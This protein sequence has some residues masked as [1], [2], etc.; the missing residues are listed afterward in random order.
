MSSRHYY[1]KVLVC[2]AAA[3]LGVATMTR[4]GKVEAGGQDAVSF[5]RDVRPIFSDT[6]FRCHGPDGN[7]RKAGLRLDIREEA[8]KK[9]KSGVIPIVP[10]KPEESEVV[11]RIFASEK[12][13]VMPPPALHKELTAQQKEI[14][15]RWIAEGARYEGHWAFQPIHRPAVPAL[16]A[17]SGGSFTRNPVDAFIEARL[18]KE[19]L[20][21]APEAD[22]QRLI[23]RVTLDL[24]GLPPTIEEIDNF[25][26]DRSPN[27][28]EKV[29]D[30]LLT[31][32]RYGERMT[33]RWLDAAR[34]ADTNGYQSDGERKMWRWR[35]WVI[36]SF[37]QNKP[38]DQFIIEQ[39]A[40]D[41][42]PNAT[43]DQKIA[44]AFN[45]NHRINSEGG[46]VPEE[47]AVEY[48]VDRVD[49]TS[50]VFMG[51]TLGCARCRDHK[52]DP[53]TQKEYY[54][55]FAYFNG[56]RESGRA[57]DQD[58]S[59]PWIAAPDREQQR[60][61]LELENRIA[62]AEAQ[63]AAMDK[64]LAV[65]QRRWEKSLL[66]RPDQQWLWGD[67]GLRV[68]TKNSFPLGR[69]H[70][71]LVA[72]D[73]T[74][75]YDL[76]SVYVDGQ[77][78]QLKLNQSI[79]YRFFK[80][81][82]ARL[83]IGGGG[84]P[85][86][87]FKGALDEARIY[88]ALP[89]ADGI[90]ILSCA[91][92]LQKIAALNPGKR[93]GTQRLKLRQ[94]FLAQA[95]PAPARRL[96]GSLAELKERRIKLV[97]EIPTLMVMEEMP[98]PKPALLLKRGAYDAPGEKVSRGTPAALPPTPKEFPDNRLGFAK[99]LVHPSNPL[100]ARVTVNRFWQMLFGTGL[101]KTTEDFG[102]QGE[103]PSHPE[104]LDSLA[105]EFR[106]SGWDVKR[107]LKTI[108]TSATYRQSSKAAPA[109]IQRDPE[110]RLHARGP[111]LRLPAEMIRDQALFVSGLLVEKTGGPSVKGYQPEGLYNDLVFN[112]TKYAQGT[113]AALY[114]RSLYTFWKRTIAPPFM[115]TFDAA[116]RET[117]VVR[118]QRTNTPLQ[119]LN[120][121]NDVTFIEAA[122]M[123]AQRAI[124]EGGATPEARLRYM[125]RLALGRFPST[126]EQ[127]IL[128]ANWRT[129]L[130][131]FRAD[132][133]GAAR[134][135]SM[136][137]KKNDP[138][139]DANQL[140]AYATVASLI[141]NLDEFV[142]KE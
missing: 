40:G 95:A 18:A 36:E 112:E 43:L 117:C 88:A 25:L 140:A 78:Q 137:E 115:L 30:R 46:I 106:E 114:R 22:R 1:K 107:L 104:L 48:V 136:G 94:A 26:N 3:L 64:R 134:L 77:K 90:A 51:L 80:I 23:R 85:D 67:D 53:I 65:A 29:V 59:A 121:M 60:K 61:L 10:G 31:S 50:T 7:A 55:L 62:R 81:K 44:T 20:R 100:T 71:A 129:Q 72:F 2:L 96:W 56:I 123:L 75:P 39:L 14:I 73:G 113:G 132:P 125:F 32:P 57:Y 19:G 6:C 34:Y 97:D 27:A 122:R 38:F 13:E 133:T 103:W 84:G 11:R 33:F 102:A 118:E 16:S 58:N 70:H 35:D 49:T 79:I 98:E 127:Q 41:L 87:R 45:R 139:L 116:N 130:D 54:Q 21:P 135:L 66:S 105:V 93:T 74:Q 24:T 69:W 86:L 109:L 111:R 119:A 138:R 99:W 142:T 47:Y 89:E 12:Y 68:E 131:Q 8:T 37:N 76:V 92:S 128:L 5:N 63:L 52:Y 4:D 126:R 82:E 42:L 124:S 110:N 28:Y 141:F 101:V 17:L 91:D 83:R 120:L 15:R 9:T 108:A